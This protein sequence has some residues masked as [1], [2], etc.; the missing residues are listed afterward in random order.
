MKLGL[1]SD[2]HGNIH[3]LDPVLERLDRERVDMILCAGDLVCY[4]VD[5]DQVLRVLHQ[6]H[7]PCVTGNYDYAVAWDQPRASHKLSS[8]MTEPVKR[9]ALDWT[10]THISSA[11]ISFLRSL[12]SLATFPLDGSSVTM[13]HA[14]PERLDE[15]LPMP[16]SG[17][18]DRFGDLARRF[19]PDIVVLGHTHRPFSLKLHNTLFVN[20]GAVG[21]SINR[22]PRA[23]FAI[24]DTQRLDVE[25]CLIDYD[26]DAAV[27]SI[28]NSEMPEGVAILVAQC[29]GRLEEVIHA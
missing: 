21:R 28:R 27:Q 3:A 10:R 29:A 17:N 24:V 23:V 11:G 26:I 14:T 2:I 13:F 19:G 16:Q 20:P 25:F 5:H 4:G 7:I 8:P 6:R 1:I 18:T 15:E 12:P 22:D 9:A